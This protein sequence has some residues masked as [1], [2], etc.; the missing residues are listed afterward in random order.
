MD[1]AN[2]W[3]YALKGEQVGPVSL[4]E[5]QGLVDEGKINLETK[6]WNGEGDWKA[7]KDTEVSELFKRQV[8]S[9]VPPPLTGS[10]VNNKFIWAVVAVPIVGVIIELLAGT[11]LVWLYIVAN[12]VC[13][14]LDE[15][16]LKKAGQKSPT[17]WMV[18]LVPVY[19]WKRAS[20]LNQKKHYFW[21]WCA[22]FVL[23]ILI[24]IGGNQA[25][26]EEAAR[27]VVTQIIQEQLYGSAECKAVSI[28][29][30]VSDGFYKATATLDNGNELRITIEERKDGQIYV[31]I[32]NQ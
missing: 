10:D 20:L 26:L 31:Q 13:C 6:V 30:E 16:K 3:Y 2:D 19:L 21:G 18:F 5:I 25:A 24:G 11:E 27:P 17:N 28:D 23:S 22:A 9:N 7:A 12:I 29:E 8:A 32:P 14:V 4:Q 15:K 1:N